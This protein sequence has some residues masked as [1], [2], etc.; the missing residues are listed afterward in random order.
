MYNI[1][2]FVI[3]VISIIIIKKNGARE[4]N[5]GKRF[6]IILSRWIFL[7]CFCVDLLVCVWALHTVSS[8]KVRSYDLACVSKIN[9]IRGI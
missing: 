7:V 6:N 1:S 9:Y 8:E 4:N 2:T 5:A 3:P